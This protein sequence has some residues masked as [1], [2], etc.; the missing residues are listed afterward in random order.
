MERFDNRKS[1]DGKASPYSEW[2][3]ILSQ[4]GW[5]RILDVA[6]DGSWVCIVV[7]LDRSEH[8]ISIQRFPGFFE[9]SSSS[10]TI[11]HA[12]KIKVAD[13]MTAIHTIDDMVLK[14]DTFVQFFVQ[15][16][17]VLCCIVHPDGFGVR[18]FTGKYAADCI[19]N[20]SESAGLHISFEQIYSVGSD[21]M[22]LPLE[23][24]SQPEL[25]TWRHHFNFHVTICAICSEIWLD[26]VPPLVCCQSC[27]S[28]FHDSC[29]REW[30]M[31]DP[32]SKRIFSRLTGKCPACDAD[33]EIFTTPP[34]IVN[35]PVAQSAV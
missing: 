14:I 34:E 11:L 8:Q 5:S 3:Y 2:F 20:L 10:L 30:M 26:Y 31:V 33:L 13:W 25:A 21:R 4:I 17:H 19:L 27:S 24:L 9:L 1:T 16:S 29:C 7:K 15:L 6:P 23:G 12:Y 28:S 18:V 32:T 22:Q 35:V